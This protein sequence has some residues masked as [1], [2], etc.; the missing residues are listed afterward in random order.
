MASVE[1]TIRTYFDA[2]NHSDVDAVV[3]VFADGRCSDARRVGDRH[4]R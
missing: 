2:L 4:R 3:A 1:D